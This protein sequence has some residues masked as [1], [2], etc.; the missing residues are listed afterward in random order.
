[1]ANK[2]GFEIMLGQVEETEYTV[3]SKWR[4]DEIKMSSLGAFDG[5]FGA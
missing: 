5:D 4:P 1:M 3:R 2:F